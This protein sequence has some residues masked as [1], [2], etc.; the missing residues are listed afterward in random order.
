MPRYEDS[1]GTRLYVGHLSSRTRSRDLEHIFSR[2]GRVRD[3]DMK[4]DYA[5]VVPRGSR[6]GAR[7]YGGRGPAPGSGCCFNCGIEGHWARDCKSGDWKNKCYRCGERG[8][9]ERDCR[10]SPKKLR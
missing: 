5:F 2:Y 8:H 6:G 1:Y 7:D 4:R 3:V 9:V 10:D